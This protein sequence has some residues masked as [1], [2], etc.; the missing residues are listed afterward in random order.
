MTDYAALLKR[1]YGPFPGYYYAIG[2]TGALVVLFYWRRKR[3][4]SADT[5]TGG[6][7]L[8]PGASG[9]GGGGGGYTPSTP[10]TPSTADCPAGT[11]RDPMTLE[12][13]PITPSTPLPPG[14]PRYPDTVV[15]TGGGTDADA[16]VRAG[17]YWTFSG[18]YPVGSWSCED[19]PRGTPPAAL[20]PP[21]YGTPTPPNGALAV[22]DAPPNAYGGWVTMARGGR[23]SIFQGFQ[24]GAPVSSESAPIPTANL[25]TD[26]AH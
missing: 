3:G 17:R 1:K 11:T 2:G 23:K 4:T 12:C 5:L 15:D 8:V 9:G 10:S 19:T 7:V 26:I 14:E 22:Y 13:L 21:A 18:T 16:C 25:T 6:G 20:N 24:G